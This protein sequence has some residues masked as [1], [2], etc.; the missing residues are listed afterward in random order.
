MAQPYRD[1]LEDLMEEHGVQEYQKRQHT[2][3]DKRI[4]ELEPIFQTLLDP[5][6]SFGI[7]QKLPI[8]T[9]IPYKTLQTWNTKVHQ[10]PNWRPDHSRPKNMI[11]TPEGE[12]E[13]RTK[14]N[15]EYIR[16]QLYLPTKKVSQIIKDYARNEKHEKKFRKEVAKFK[17]SLKF[18]DDFLKRNDLALRTYHESRRTDPNDNIVAKFLDDFQ[19][20]KQFIPHNLIINADETSWHFMH[21]GKKTITMKG[22]DEVACKCHEGI[23]GKECLTVMATIALDGTKLPL[24]VI[25]KGKTQKLQKEL[26]NASELIPYIRQKQLFFTNSESGWTDKNVAITYIDWIHNEYAKGQECIFMWDVYSSHRDE[27]AKQFAL[28]NNVG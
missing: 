27:N 28:D 5:R 3:Y 1:P 24:M 18:T 12:Q 2:V 14:L 19:V 17:N 11:F 15:D 7:I 13:I 22:V 4:N 25:C 20:A 8:R 9:T 26:E 23:G 16:P 21:Q 10:D 6:A